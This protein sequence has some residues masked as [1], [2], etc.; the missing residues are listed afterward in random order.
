MLNDQISHFDDSVKLE[1]LNKVSE[2]CALIISEGYQIPS[3]LCMK[4]KCVP[5]RLSEKSRNS[6][7]GQFI[8]EEE[9]I[10]QSFQSN[11]N[12]NLSVIL[13]NTA[14]SNTIDLSFGY[15]AISWIDPPSQKNDFACVSAIRLQKTY[16]S[17]APFIER[18]NKSK[19]SSFSSMYYQAKDDRPERE[20]RISGSGD[21]NGNSRAEGSITFGRDFDD[22]SRFEM[23]GRA[24]V[25]QKADGTTTT[26][27]GG[28]A[29][30]KW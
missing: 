5:K 30:Y 25:E 6:A 23:S 11:S 8:G 10:L 26:N 20:A 28:D 24:S 4:P 18:H 2:Q 7:S 22:G 15:Q 14:A 9:T 12:Q 13:K 19:T 17:Q 1:Q 3:V 27:V 29:S 21:S 16:K